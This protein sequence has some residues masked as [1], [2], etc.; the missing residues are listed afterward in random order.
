[1]NPWIAVIL[2]GVGLAANVA[3]VVTHN[4][5]SS[6]IPAVV[7]AG[8]GALQGLAHANFRNGGSSSNG[9]SLTPPNGTRP[10]GLQ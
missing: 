3:L 10:T 9:P 8:L 6:L 1:M 2:I 4:E 7:I 5:V